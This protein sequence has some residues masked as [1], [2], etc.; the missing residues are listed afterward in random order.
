MSSWQDY[1]FSGPLSRG[2]QQAN[3][4]KHVRS[5]SNGFLFRRMLGCNCPRKSRNYVSVWMLWGNFGGEVLGAIFAFPETVSYPD[6]S[7][8]EFEDM[9]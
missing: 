2:S 8:R 5:A 9:E 7:D 4:S 1:Q 3:V 6:G